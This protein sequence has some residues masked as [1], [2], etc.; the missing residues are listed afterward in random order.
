MFV[1]DSLTLYN[2]LAAQTELCKLKNYRKL[3]RQGGEGGP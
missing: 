1:S 3:G 2:I